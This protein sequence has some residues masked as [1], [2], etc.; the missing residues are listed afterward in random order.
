MNNREMILEQIGLKDEIINKSDINIVT[1]GNC[2]AVVLHRLTDEEIKCPYCGFESEPCD[3]P[4][5]LHIGCELSAIH[6][7]DEGVE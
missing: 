3:F 2:G 1:C 4:D 6:D 7:E 5:F